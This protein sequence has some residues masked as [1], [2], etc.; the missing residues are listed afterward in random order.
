VAWGKIGERF[1][2]DG[3]DGNMM[4]GGGENEGKTGGELGYSNLGSGLD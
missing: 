1:G 2:R 3:G 4:G